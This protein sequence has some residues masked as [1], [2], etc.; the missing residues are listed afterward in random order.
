MLSALALL[1]LIS[2][3]FAAFSVAVPIHFRAHGRMPTGMR[4]ISLASVAGYALFLAIDLPRLRSDM[5][6]PR[7]CGAAPLAAGSLCLFAWAWTATRS[8]RLTLAFS[9]DVPTFVISRGPYR[10]IRHPFYTSYVMFWLATAVASHS[11]AGCIAPLALGLLY[12]R[13]ARRE[14]RKFLSSPLSQE[15]KDY[16]LRTGM[17]LPRLSRFRDAQTP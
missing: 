5:P 4:V 9:E 15:Y 10:V 11:V 12:L 13:A 14:E 8:R 6:A 1:V 2:A 17:F 3:C 16:K 7:L